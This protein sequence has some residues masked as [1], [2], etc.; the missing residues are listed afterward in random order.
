MSL[1][2]IAL[3]IE[4]LKDFLNYLFVIG[5]GCSD[6]FIIGRV[7]KIADFSDFTCNSVN[8]LLGCDTLG[9]GDFFNLLT[10]L[11]RAG[12]EENVIA[13]QSLVSCDCV[14][15]YD[16][17]AVAYMRLTRSVSDGGRNVKFSFAH[18]IS[19]SVYYCHVK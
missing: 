1:V 16:L 3:I 9:G 4:L 17:I 6:K 5:V 14:G 11:I 2:D 18:Y 12:L 15:H 13:L 8:V 10:V 19:S 7:E